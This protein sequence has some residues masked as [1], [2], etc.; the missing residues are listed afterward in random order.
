VSRSKLTQLEADMKKCFRCSLCKMVPLPTVLDARYSNGCPANRELHFH[1]YSGSG[2]SITSLSLLEGRIEVDEALAE[3]AFA[4][5]ACGLCDVSCKFIME[6]ERHQI[7]MALREHV[8]DEGFGPAAHRRMIEHLEAHG[9]PDGAARLSASPWAEGLGLKVAPTDSAPVL[10]FAGCGASR[11]ADASDA[12]AV[13]RKLALLL[14][15]A[16]VDF[17][18]LGDAEDC[19]GLPAYWT[20]HR[21]VFKKIA[22]DRA[23]RLDELGVETIVVAS[24]SCLGAMRA[25]Y[26]EYARPPRAQVVHAT[27][28]LARLIEERKLRLP[29]PVTRKVTYHDPC[30]LGRQSEPPLVWQGETKKT[31]GCMTYADPPREINRGVRGVFDPPRRILRAIRGLDFVEMHR[32]R[33]YAFCCGGGGGVPEAYPN[34]ARTTALH[35]LE[36]ATGVGAEC[37]VT[38]CHHCR[39]NLTGAQRPAGNGLPVVDIIDLVYEAAAIE[40]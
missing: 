5:T 40:A 23:R 26:P 9:H 15:R 18:I 13:V 6:A 34:L 32:I 39:A 35:R 12:S 11:E 38:A 7:N 29:R 31:R 10:L 4:C 24:G 30:Y 28:F 16:G 8:V 21:D 2:K 1:G 14:S 37:L 17:M 22:A 27:E 33:E 20:G 25:K 19:C 36:E 3:I